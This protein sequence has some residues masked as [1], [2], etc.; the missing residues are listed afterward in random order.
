M[1]VKPNKYR[2]Q[3]CVKQGYDC[4]NGKHLVDLG[5]GDSVKLCDE[6]YRRWQEGQ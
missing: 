4:K 6:C 3:K 5:H 1:K 2:K